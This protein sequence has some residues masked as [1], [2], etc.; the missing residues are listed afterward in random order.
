MRNFIVATLL[1]LSSQAAF[2]AQW[3]VLTSSDIES[4]QII[5]ANNSNGSPEGLYIILKSEIVGEAALYCTKKN[6]IVISDSKLI[7][8]TYSGLLFAITTQKT[9][10]LYVD[11][12]GKCLANI[13][14]VTA[15]ILKP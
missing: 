13:P 6:A 7:D 1:M 8:R 10:Q 15:F 9:F 5:Q 3:L 12:S 14:L 11:G 2:S 4:I